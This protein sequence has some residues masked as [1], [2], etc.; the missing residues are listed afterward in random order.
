MTEDEKQKNAENDPLLK[1]KRT[2]SLE[3]IRQIEGEIDLLI[4]DVFRR[5][6]KEQEMKFEDYQ[7]VKKN[8][9]SITKL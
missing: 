8:A 2:L 1:L 7:E 4:D 3:K 9:D 6:D 5:A